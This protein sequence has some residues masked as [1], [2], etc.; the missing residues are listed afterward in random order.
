[1][2]PVPTEAPIVYLLSRALF[3]AMLVPLGLLGLRTPRGRYGPDLQYAAWVAASPIG[4]PA[5]WLHYQQLLMLPLLVLAAV[6][7]SGRGPRPGW[8]QLGLF[9]AALA[10][11]AFGDHYTVLGQDAGEL[12]KQQTARVDAANER[13]LA[14]FAGPRMLLVSYKLYGALILLGL[15]LWNG[16]RSSA[17]EGWASLRLTAPRREEP[18]TV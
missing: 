12:W 5:S 6:W 7:W 14:E 15:C 2:R 1:M 3:V 9:A 8:L 16:W 11:I 18:A 17:W 13:L 10:L 4:I